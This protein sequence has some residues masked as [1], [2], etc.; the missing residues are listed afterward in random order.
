[1]ANPE[2]AVFLPRFFQVYPGGYGEG[3]RFQGVNVPSQRRVCQA[4]Y[5]ENTLAASYP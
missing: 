3:D 4:F 2:K 1:M 5:Q